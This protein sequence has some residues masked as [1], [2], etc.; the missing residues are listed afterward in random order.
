MT[1]YKDQKETEASLFLI[2]LT[3]HHFEASLIL[4]FTFLSV[5]FAVY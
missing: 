1:D 3:S 2:A 5:P 4:T